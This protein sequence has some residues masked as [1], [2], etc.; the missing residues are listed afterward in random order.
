[1]FG[2]IFSILI[3]VQLGCVLCLKK[4]L[5]ASDKPQ[6]MLSKY[7]LQWRYF[8][9]VSWTE[10]DRQRTWVIRLH[11]TLHIN[12]FY[13]YQSSLMHSSQDITLLTRLSSLPYITSMGR[14]FVNN[15][16]SKCYLRLAVSKGMFSHSGKS[17]IIFNI[18]AGNQKMLCCLF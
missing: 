14:L 11:S 7:F 4:P 13:Q 17:Q 2:N 15:I 3:F 8:C 18:Y 6:L 9:C 12:T 5:K 10:T 16:I 1:M